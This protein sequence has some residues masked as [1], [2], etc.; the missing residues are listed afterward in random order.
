MF[1]KRIMGEKELPKS[2]IECK[3]ADCTGY[4]KILKDRQEDYALARH[5][6]CPLEVEDGKKG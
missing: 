3:E 2:C 4:C 6:D 5:K 1:R